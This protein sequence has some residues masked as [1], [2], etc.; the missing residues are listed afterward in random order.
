MKKKSIEE[1][2]LSVL[3]KDGRKMYKT[4]ELF[5]KT[6]ISNSE[7]PE[8]KALLREM[9][10]SGRISRGKGGRYGQAQARNILEGTLHVKTQGFGF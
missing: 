4:R 9:A 2:I 8:F 1:E 5:R 7:Y 3:E 6:G 10:E